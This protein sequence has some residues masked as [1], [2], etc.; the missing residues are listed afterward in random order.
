[1]NLDRIIAVSSSKTV[2]RDGERCLKVFVRERNASAVLREAMNQTLL[3]E[4]G[5][6]VPPVEEVTRINGHWAIVSRYIRGVTLARQMER[7]PARVPEYL[8]RLARLQ[9]ELHTRSCPALYRLRDGLAERRLPPGTPELCRR[10]L[11]E[12]AERMNREKRICHGDYVPDNVIETPEGELYLV[13]C[14]RSMAGDPA[15][16]AAVTVC[17][18]LLMKPAWSEAYLRLYGTEEAMR[19]RV[20]ALLP[21]AAS[22]L[23]PDSSEEARQRLIGRIEDQYRSEEA[24][25]QP[26][27]SS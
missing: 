27:I 12:G 21:A 15:F 20:E 11:R 9:R 8:E 4:A 17:R 19:R 26:R 7:E 24:P 3:W 23:L 14:A 16:D 10:A 2:Y 22:F 25:G 6:P 1:M 13:D 5:L 18:L